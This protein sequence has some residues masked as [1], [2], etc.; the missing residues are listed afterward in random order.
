MGLFLWVCGHEINP[1]VGVDFHVCIKCNGRA[2]RPAP[3][4]KKLTLR[5]V[6]AGF[7]VCPGW[8]TPARQ[9]EQPPD[10]P[11]AEFWRLI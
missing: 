4:G 10:N 3:T 7:H 6:G 8:G 9:K 5:T 11:T 2:Q 1:I